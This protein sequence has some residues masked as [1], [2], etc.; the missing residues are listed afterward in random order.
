M[1]SAEA[2]MTKAHKRDD[3]KLREL[4]L[5]L[6]RQSEGDDTFGA[7]KLNKELF[8]SDFLAYL[9]FGQSI[10]GHDYIA[11]ERGPA[12]KYKMEI[13]DGM[14]KRGDLAVRKH[15]AFGD[16]QDRAFALR[17]PK[18]DKF[19][20]EEINLVH[21][22]VGQCHE[23]S[24]RDLSA[25]SHAFLGWRLAKEKEVIPYSVALV[26]KREPTLDEIKWGQELEPMAL[27]CLGRH[28]RAAAEA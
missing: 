19:T 15:E 4:I 23:K 2:N 22:V 6:A 12:P 9:H 26:G 1:A 7:V 24:G 20:K 18:L 17:E 3:D 28:E 25:M 10:T 11:L 21:Y 16:V 27:E 14:V 5:L 13:I 8:Y